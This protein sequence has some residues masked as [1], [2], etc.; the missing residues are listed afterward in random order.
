MINVIVVPEVESFKI[1]VSYRN[2]VWINKNI[3]TPRLK[4]RN[5]RYLVPYWLTKDIK[6]VNRIYHIEGFDP[7]N[8]EIILGNSFIIRNSW[9]KMGNHRKYE[10]HTLES[11][12]FV[13]VKEGLLIPYN[14]EVK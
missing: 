8:N 11:F 6:G 7:K 4:E 12:D 3:G 10:Y 9:D 1:D 13:E 5:A 14:F 2:V